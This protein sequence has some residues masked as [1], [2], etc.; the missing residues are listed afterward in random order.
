MS[1]TFLEISICNGMQTRIFGNLRTATTN[2]KYKTIEDTMIFYSAQAPL[3]L[4]R[5]NQRRFEH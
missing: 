4:L 3:T 5:V 1:I 2:A